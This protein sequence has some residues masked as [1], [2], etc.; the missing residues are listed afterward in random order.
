MYMYIHIYI[1]VFTYIYIHIYAYI[2]IELGFRVDPMN[3]RVVH[4]YFSG[5]TQCHCV[6]VFLSC[7]GQRRNHARRMRFTSVYVYGSFI[8]MCLRVL[9]FVTG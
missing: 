1:C 8:F 7:R 2:Y 5:F 4:S 6:F 9:F 3:D